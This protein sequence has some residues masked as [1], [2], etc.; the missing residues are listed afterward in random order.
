MLEPTL[1]FKCLSDPT[2]LKSLLLIN[3]HK[4]LCVCDLITATGEN[5]SKISRHL[6]QL[7]TNGL[8]KDRRHNQWVYYSL[9]PTLPQ[10]ALDVINITATQETDA[11]SKLSHTLAQSKNCCN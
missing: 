4:E 7:R 1:F 5:Q 10:W 6:S 3:K 8:L 9:H 2:R 11:I